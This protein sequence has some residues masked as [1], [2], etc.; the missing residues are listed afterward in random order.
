MLRAEDATAC[1][2]LVNNP[3]FQPGGDLMSA[4]YALAFRFATE[5]LQKEGM[6]DSKAGPC[7]LACIVRYVATSLGFRV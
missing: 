4:Q 7:D 6:M 3:L 2:R 5:Y 1:A